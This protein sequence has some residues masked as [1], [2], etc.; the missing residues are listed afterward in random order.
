MEEEIIDVIIVGAGIAGSTS[1]LLLAQAGFSVL[2]LERGVQAGSKNC[3]GGRLYSHSLELIIP[4]FTKTAPLERAIT[5]ERLSM[6]TG[7][8][9]TTLDYRQPVATAC[10][11]SVLRSRFDPWLMTLAEAAGAQCLTD[12][13]VDELV[14]EHGRIIGV[15]IG[16]D[17]LFSRTVIL[18][19]GANTLLAEQHQLMPKPTP[20]TMATGVKEILALPRERLEERFGLEGDQGCAWM[21]AGQPTGGKVGGGFLYTNRDTLSLGV[22][23]NLSQLGSGPRSLPQMLDDFKSHPAIRPLLKGCEMQEYSAHLI[24]EGG[25]EHLPPL[26]GDGW[27]LVGDAAR[28]CIHAGHTMR[29]M[30]L[31]VTSAQAA[32][33]TLINARRQQDFSARSLS[34]YL[35]HLQHSAVWPLMNQYHRLPQWLLSSPQLFNEYP[36]LTAELLHEL[37]DV[38]GQPPK[39][40]RKLLWDHVR[41][42]GLCRLLKD[43]LKGVRSL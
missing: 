7:D 36:Q 10:S 32:A 42:A 18:A 39:T 24:P 17:T 5:Q 22:V 30:D 15:K 26:S 23:C 2:L 12:V 38:S 1:A 27:L 28:L 35:Q 16:E 34:H 33:T 11:W 29:G 4:D 9:M 40:L 8:S 21:F 3:S 14:M 19:E 41:K 43:S 13:V 37:F 20:R 6:M 25:I 31:A